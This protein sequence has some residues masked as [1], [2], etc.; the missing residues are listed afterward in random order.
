MTPRNY[1]SRETALADT[2]TQIAPKASP[3]VVQ[4]MIC[5]YADELARVFEKVNDIGV[6]QCFYRALKIATQKAV[7]TLL[8]EPSVAGYPDVVLPPYVYERTGQIAEQVLEELIELREMKDIHDY[9]LKQFEHIAFSLHKWFYVNPGVFLEIL[10]IDSRLAQPIMEG[11][12]E[13]RVGEGDLVIHLHIIT[14]NGRDRLL[15]RGIAS[16]YEHWDKSYIRDISSTC[17]DICEANPS[18]KGVFNDGSWTCDPANFQTASDGKS[19][20]SFDF[21]ADDRAVGKR[22][23]VADA[24]PDNEH[25]GQ[26]QFATRNQRRRELYNV[27]EFR[28]KVYATFLPR[29]QM[30]VD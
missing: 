6:P 24:L 20:V 30:G 14:Q 21:L 8:R 26:W 4:A 11:L 2:Y 29:E 7:D 27:G 19:F 18:I 12:K 5:R 3:T 22:I 10:E 28:P 1:P 15:A 25:Q 16:P 17:R 13:F 23:Y 9:M